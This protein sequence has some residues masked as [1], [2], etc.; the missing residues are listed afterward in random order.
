MGT[1]VTIH[2]WHSLL[3]ELHHG[4][5]A[6][7]YTMTRESLIQLMHSFTAA[8]HYLGWF[9]LGGRKGHR[10]EL[11]NIKQLA[12]QGAVVQTYNLNCLGGWGKG[13]PSLKPAWTTNQD[14]ISKPKRNKA[15]FCY[16]CWFCFIL[17]CF[18]ERALL[19]SPCWPRTQFLAAL[20]TQLLAL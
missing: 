8:L 18:W 20:V 7:L 9:C 13:S 5:I 12:R 4:H 11:R 14:L 15:F 10:S 6:P 19:S 3:W 1:N 2:W 16:C 17:F